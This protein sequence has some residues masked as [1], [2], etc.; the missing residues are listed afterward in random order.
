MNNPLLYTL[1]FSQMYGVSA[2]YKSLLIKTFGSAYAIYQ[3]R[4]KGVTAVTAIEKL[5]P[6]PLWPHGL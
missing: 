4:Q 1:A 3:E 6:N 5:N 2:Y